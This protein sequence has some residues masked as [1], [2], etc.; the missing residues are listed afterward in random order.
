MYYMLPHDTQSKQI[1]WKTFAYANENLNTL[2]YNLICMYLLYHFSI[3]YHVEFFFWR[4][5]YQ[6][7]AHFCQMTE[8]AQ[9]KPTGSSTELWHTTR[10]L[11]AKANRKIPNS[12]SE[13]IFIENFVV[14]LQSCRPLRSWSKTPVYTS[15]RRNLWHPCSMLFYH[16][17]K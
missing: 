3:K 17:Y 7:S 9:L 12:K 6:I 11:E 1:N 15:I 8:L 13:N 16:L 2:I 14:W 10:L 5:S 4:L